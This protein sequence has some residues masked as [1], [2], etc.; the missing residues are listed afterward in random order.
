MLFEHF[1]Q[2]PLNRIANGIM[3]QAIPA[4]HKQV[5]PGTSRNVAAINKDQDRVGDVVQATRILAIK[6]ILSQMAVG[7][8]IDGKHD[9]LVATIRLGL[10]CFEGVNRR[11]HCYAFGTE[12]TR[13]RKPFLAT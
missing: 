6:K 2:L 7:L 10:G 11:G 5:F 13:S 9:T 12:W 3:A 1:L 8:T 4:V